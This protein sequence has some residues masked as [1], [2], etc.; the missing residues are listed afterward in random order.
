MKKFVF[1]YNASPERGN[2]TDEDWF[3]W[4]KSIGENLIDIGNPIQGG[5]LVKGGSSTELT[6]FTDFVGGYSLISAES[7]EEAITIAQG[8]PSAAGVR[9][10]EALPM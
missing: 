8:C 6:S 9:V 5:V 4:F 3:A 10:F 2:D 7:I 1:I